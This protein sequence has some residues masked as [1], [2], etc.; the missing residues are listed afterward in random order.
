MPRKHRM[1]G[2]HRDSL[3]KKGTDLSILKG[4][5]ASSNHQS[6]DMLVFRGVIM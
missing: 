6:S 4:N 1:T 2:N 3:G 5:E